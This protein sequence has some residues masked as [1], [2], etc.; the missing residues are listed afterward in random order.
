MRRSFI[1][2]LSLQHTL[3]A[4]SIP[5]GRQCKSIAGQSGWPGVTA[6][7]KLNTTLSGALLEP[8]PPARPCYDPTTN[9]SI[10]ALCD[11]TTASWLSSSFHTEDPVSLAYPSLQDDACLPPSL[12]D[13][14]GR[15]D[16]SAFPKYV[17]NASTATHVAE[18][19]KFAAANNV[20]IVVKGGAHDL[21]GRYVWFH[22]ITHLFCNTNPSR[23]TAPS[24]LSLWTR[25]LRG[26][27]YHE[28]FSACH[29]DL[30]QYTAVTAAAGH[31]VGEIQQL[32]AEHS[33][34]IVGGADPG[35][36]IGGY[37]TGG[38]HSPLGSLHGMGVD[39]VLELSLVTPSGDVVTASPCQNSDLFWAVRGVRVR[40]L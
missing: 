19:V 20:R 6:W 38:G 26:L 32:V 39:N 18:T 31:L 1:L 22:S 3:D 24:V 23:S 34:T 37:L 36:G 28:S 14:E 7:K 30:V 12:I 29:S 11:Y 5:N 17:V 9:G 27:E 33:M 15:C 40:T 35:I 4:L 2:L 13:G 16:L 10:N 25:N 21:L 8:T